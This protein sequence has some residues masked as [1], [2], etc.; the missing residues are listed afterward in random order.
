MKIK[1][2]QTKKEIQVNRLF[3]GNVT[4]QVIIDTSLS[5]RFAIKQVNFEKGARNKFHA[6]S[7]EQILI[8]T[9][10]EGIVATD[11]EEMIVVPGDIVFIAADEKHWHGATKD[12][13][14]SHLYV[15]APEQQTTQLED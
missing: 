9:E 4:Q 12:S 7:I 13:T 3:A 10:G 6:H 11:K 15:M 2:G 8:I 14:F 5:N 1:I